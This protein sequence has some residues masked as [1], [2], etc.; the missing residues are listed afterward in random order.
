MKDKFNQVLRLINSQSN[1]FASQFDRDRLS[2]Q[3]DDLQDMNISTLD[4]EFTDII[5]QISIDN[6]LSR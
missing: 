3:L 5:S 6:V 1:Q 4:F 2:S